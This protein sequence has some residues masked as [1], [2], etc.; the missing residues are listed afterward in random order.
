MF[1]VDPLWWRY[2]G[3]IDCGR[4]RRRDSREYSNVKLIFL[5]VCIFLIFACIFIADVFVVAQ[6]GLTAR[7]TGV[8]SSFWDFK[9]D[10]TTSAD[11]WGW[12][13]HDLVG[14]LHSSATSSPAVVSVGGSV[15]GGYANNVF[16]VSS[17]PGV[18]PDSDMVLLG[19]VRFRQLRVAKGE[20][21]DTFNYYHIGTMCAEDYADDQNASHDSF[22]V[23]GYPMY[24]NS[25]FEWRNDCKANSVAGKTTGLVYG[26]NGF[27]F[28]LPVDEAEAL[29]A[30]TDLETSNWVD[31]QTSAVIVEVNTFHA[32]S[33]VFVVDRF[34]FEF[35][36]A[37]LG[38]SAHDSFVIPSAT[39]SL[40]STDSRSQIQLGLD[41]FCVMFF[42][43][44][45]TWY[46]YQFFVCS[47]QR[48]WNFVGFHV[49]TIFLLLTILLIACRA[50]MYA[51]MTEKVVGA[52][53]SLFGH[54]N[55]FVPLSLLTDLQ[56]YILTLQAVLLLLFIIRSLKFLYLT[57]PGSFSRNVFRFSAKS[58]REFFSV[59]VMAAIV[60]I[61]FAM[62]Y[63]VRIGYS[64]SDYTSPTASFTSVGLSLIGVLNIKSDWIWDNKFIAFVSLWYLFVIYLML[65]PL[66]FAVAVWAKTAVDQTSEVESP[67]FSSGESPLFV[68]CKTVWRNWFSRAIPVEPL[69]EE[70]QGLKIDLLPGVV[71]KRIQVRRK[72]LKAKVENALRVAAS[73]YDEYDDFVSISELRKIIHEDP[74][75]VSLMGFST[76]E[77]I[78]DKLHNDSKH[79]LV[80]ASLTQK[81]HTVQT[82]GV[83]YG[84][85]MNPNILLVS[86]ELSAMIDET[87]AK[88]ERELAPLTASV[89]TLNLAARQVNSRTHTT[90][91]RP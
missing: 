85:E 4:V 30:L 67:N 37:N 68:F 89:H 22:F 51:L 64:D 76:A 26:A 87:R 27:V 45:V 33:D 20:C 75:I 88:I 24:L 57:R 82:A 52:N 40:T 38:I 3:H 80:E 12:A 41:A 50:Y 10:V 79:D 21:T 71:R 2:Y 32:I 9:G 70:E 14:R 28:D 34:L 83:Q 8:H 90:I 53:A 74:F 54:P 23:S 15:V 11:F 66:L 5:E 56:E 49:D 58:F 81:I 73:H 35:S 77:E 91:S 42:M 62:A 6:S 47:I 13:A 39:V 63:Y 86:N 18:I 48:L 78:I 25:A 59:A 46:L 65:Y 84:V 7:L 31:A 72:E 69:D 29:Q 43:I 1:L 44:F 60:L 19:P 36:S 16:S 17:T 55:I 61:G